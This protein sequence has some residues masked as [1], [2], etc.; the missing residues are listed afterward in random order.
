MAKYLNS[1]ISNNTI[2]ERNIAYI[3]RKGFLV[4]KPS[5]NQSNIEFV[6]SKNSLIYPL[7]GINQIGINI[8]KDIITEREK[9]G[10]FNSFEDFKRRMPGLGY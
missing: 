8:A 1:V 5:I 2:I 7:Q 3:R 4:L 9:N 6:S 10:L